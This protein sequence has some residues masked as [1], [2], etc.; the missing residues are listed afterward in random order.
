[1]QNAKCKM[2][3]TKYKFLLLEFLEYQHQHQ[4]D[5]Y[6]LLH[7]KYWIFEKFQLESVYKLISR[8]V[9]K[10]IAFC[11]YTVVDRIRGICINT[12]YIKEN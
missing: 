11:V 4:L 6:I 1:M 10:S 2:Q 5:Y 3:N 7:H 9:Y 12:K 8:K